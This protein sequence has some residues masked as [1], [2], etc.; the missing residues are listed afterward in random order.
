MEAHNAISA[1]IA[2]EAGFEGLW[3]SGLSLSASMGVRDNNELSY[4]QVLDVLEFIDEATTIPLLLDGDTGYG[5]FNNMRMLVRK[6]DARHIA[7]VCIEDKLFP[8]TNS[9]IGENQPLADIDEFCG[10]IKAGK[11]AQGDRD[12]TIVARVEALIA[13]H[14]MAEALHRAEA[15]RLAGAD[16]VLIH[17]KLSR[18][19]EILAFLK[20]WA[21]RAPVVIVPTTYYATPTDVFRRAGVSTIIWAN[22]LLR[23]SIAAMRR[24]AAQIFAER[25][26]VNVE[27]RIAPLREVFRL[28]G[29]GEL[30]EAEK[31]YLPERL[32]PQAL[33]LAASR[34]SELGDLTANCPK[35]LLPVAG[36]PLLDRLTETLHGAGVRGVTVVR[37]YRKETIVRP[38]LRFVDNNEYAASSEVYSLYLGL[39]GITQPG[40]S[41]LLVSYGD[42]LYQKHIPADLLQRD[43]DFVIAV[44]ADWERSRN[45]GRYGDFVTCT[46]PYSKLDFSSQTYL[47]YARGGEWRADSAIH[48]EW[49]GLLK[50]S[51][52]GAARLE[53]LLAEMDAQD[54]LKRMRMPAVFNLLIERGERI[55]VRYSRGSWLD[56]DEVKDAIAASAFG[57]HA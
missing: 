46:E 18:P 1:K 20:E 21:A 36:T 2:E 22:H 5:N 4:T 42:I 16:A 31:R 7:G 52:S 39:R 27:D 12:F 54:S 57:A 32:A 24:T 49:M 19:D 53:T 6:L 55:E 37:G 44:D 45:I 28:Q 33:V 17:S 34:G 14:G 3:G 23:S 40:R 25:S 9:F 13:G 29:A 41:P 10:K 43:S 51:P 48:G 56:L 38:D 8:K 30:Q 47:V 35:V 26:V 11:D 15:Y 50:L